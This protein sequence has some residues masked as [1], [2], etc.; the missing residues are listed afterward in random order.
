MQATI[1]VVAGDGVGPEVV[2]QGLLALEAIGELIDGK[3]GE[4]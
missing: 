4:D 1:A 3:F 2:E